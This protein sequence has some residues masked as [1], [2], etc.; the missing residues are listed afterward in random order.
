[1]TRKAFYV[2][3]N[4]LL[5]GRTFKGYN[6]DW[7]VVEEGVNW[8]GYLCKTKGIFKQLKE[9][10]KYYIIPHVIDRNYNIP[11]WAMQLPDIIY[12]DNFK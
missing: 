11:A 4:K 6:L 5:D 9:G 1:M 8:D 3:L 7:Q 10:K 12:P 2:R